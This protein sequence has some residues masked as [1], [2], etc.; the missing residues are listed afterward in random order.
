MNA[1]EPNLIEQL[2]A[3]VAARIAPAIPLDIDLWSAAEIAAY[4]KVGARQVIDRYAPL[5]DFPSAI[6]LPTPNG[7]TG[8]PR[9]RAAEIIA[10]TTKYQEGGSRPG[11]PRMA[12]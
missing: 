2:A 1:H 4:L 9:W 11:R 10:W 12:A 8:Q 7:G 5:P 6:R 3:A